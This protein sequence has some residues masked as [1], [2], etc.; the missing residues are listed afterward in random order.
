MNEGNN[1]AFLMD[2]IENPIKSV[3]QLYVGYLKEEIISKEKAKNGIEIYGSI[4][5]LLDGKLGKNGAEFIGTY[6][7]KVVD[8]AKSV[9]DALEI[10]KGEK[11]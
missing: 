8:W 11:K 1:I 10:E 5:C 7:R 2:L 6:R 3:L 9:I 4:S